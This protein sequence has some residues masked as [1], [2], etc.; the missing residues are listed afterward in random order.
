[1]KTLI[2]KNIKLIALVAIFATILTLTLS[3]LGNYVSAAAPK[4]T[5]YQT[6]NNLDESF[7][8]ILKALHAGNPMPTGS[9]GEGYLFT[10]K[11]THSVAIEL[12][13]FTNEGNF[14][15]EVSQQIG[16]EKLNIT[17]DRRIYTIEVIVDELLYVN[18]IVLDKDGNKVQRIEFINTFQ[19]ASTDPSL[20][21]DPPIKK[22]V[23]GKP[24]Y[25]TTFEFVLEAGDKSYPMPSGSV[26]GTKTIRIA[27]SGQGEFGTWSYT[28]AGTYYYTIYEVDTKA[29]GYTYDT[30][31]YTITDTV[32]EEGSQLILKRVV[33]NNMNKPVNSCSFINRFSEG[34]EG[35]K[36]GDDS[37]IAFYIAMLTV[38]SILSIFLIT[39]LIVGS[40]TKRKIEVT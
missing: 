22:T 4:V 3:S 36:T 9:T 25:E 40:R 23:S 27:G 32:K 11:G 1:M 14:R 26:N 7:S 21:T 18:V 39:Y 6:V 34:K 16:T 10:I 24:N 19:A 30:A 17:Y 15:Y 35:P 20:M 38:S 5:V 37:N 33:T 8:Y 2:T 29:S 13:E 28:K 12:P 31:V